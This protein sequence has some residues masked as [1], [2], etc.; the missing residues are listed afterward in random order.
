MNINILELYYKKYTDT[1]KP[2]DYV[3]WAI[4]SLHMD[5][6]EIKKL[7]SMKEPYN[8]FEIE[9]MFEKAMKAIQREAPTIEVCVHNHIKQLHSHLLLS[10]KHA[11]DIVKELYQCALNYELIEVQ[12]EWQEISDAMDDLQYGDNLY[13]YTEEKINDW[14]VTHARKLWHTK[15]SNIRFDDIIGKQVTAIDSDVNF[16]VELDKGVIIIECP[17]RIRDRDVIV[18]GDMDVKVNSSEWKT[19]RDLLVGKIIVDIQLFEQNPL[20]IIQIGDVFLDIFH[21]STYYDGWTITDGEDFYLFS[22]HGGS[23]A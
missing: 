2:T 1:V 13:Q 23:I 5:V 18:L 15:R 16:I 20:L 3:E 9:D 6:L 14:I 22:M 7:A 4:S 17:W 21:S 12:M 10:N 11:M 19:A 8:L